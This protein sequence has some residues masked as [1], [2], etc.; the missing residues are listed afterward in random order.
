VLAPDIEALLLSGAGVIGTN[1]SLSAAEFMPRLLC[2][3]RAEVANI[4]KTGS[5][6]QLQFP[7]E[8]LG[9]VYHA[10]SSAV[11]QHPQEPHNS[12]RSIESVKHSIAHR[13]GGARKAS[14]QQDMSAPTSLGADQEFKPSFIV[15]GRLPHFV[16]NVAA[17]C[18]LAAGTAGKLHECTGNSSIAGMYQNQHFIKACSVGGH[19]I[20]KEAGLCVS[21]IDIPGM[22]SS[23][24]VLFLLVTYP[25]WV[26]LLQ[27]SKAMPE[28]DLFRSC[29]TMVKLMEDESCLGS[30]S[31]WAGWEGNV[32]VVAACCTE[33]ELPDSV[34][35][36]A[37]EV[38]A[39]T[40]ASD[41]GAALQETEARMHTDIENIKQISAQLSATG[42]CF[43][44]FVPGLSGLHVCDGAELAVLARPDGHIARI[45]SL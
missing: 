22:I 32:D 1:G 41:Q 4:F 37:S 28:G 6:L 33:A 23:K 39:S 15:G 8:D 18:S 9:F 27:E 5:T 16:L 42:V 36:P 38:F 13:R 43:A 17:P 24:W 45:G 34:H 14:H 26:R 7:A 31:A 30:T 44:R 3:C 19:D 29:P 25:G 10:M 21:S 2:V 20:Q 35:M 11:T 12:I 40:L